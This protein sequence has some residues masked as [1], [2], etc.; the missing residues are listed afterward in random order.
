MHENLQEN[1]VVNGHTFRH[2]LHTYVCIKDYYLV[3]SKLDLERYLRSKIQFRTTL[4]GSKHAKKL[5]SA[6][7]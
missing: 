7:F 3:G 5:N 4:F 1:L 6:S 2:E